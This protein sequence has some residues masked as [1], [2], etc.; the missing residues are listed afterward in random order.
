[1][2]MQIVAALL[3]V[4]RDRVPDAIFPIRLNVDFASATAPSKGR[5]R[6]DLHTE[7][8]RAKRR[9]ARIDNRIAHARFRRIA[10]PLD[11]RLIIGLVERLGIDLFEIAADNQV[12][13]R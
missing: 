7:R 5:V 9:K 11:S 13:F 2:D 10:R 8:F 12:A 6:P 1:M 4:G 3:G